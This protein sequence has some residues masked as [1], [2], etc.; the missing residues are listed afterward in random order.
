MITDADIKKLRKVFV[1]KGDLQAM[2]ERQDRKYATKDGVREDIRNLKEDLLDAMKKQKEEIIES[3]AEVIR[4]GI[5]P[6]L[7]DHE[8]RIAKLEKR[9]PAIA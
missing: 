5:N 1:T 7:D 6:I 2:E 8:G 4:D 9:M 3:V